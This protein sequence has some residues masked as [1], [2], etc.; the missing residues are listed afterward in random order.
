[1]NIKRIWTQTRFYPLLLAGALAFGAT[2]VLAQDAPSNDQSG[3]YNEQGNAA[4]AAETLASVPESTRSAKLYSVLGATYDQQ[5]DYKKA[6]EMY[7]KAVALD[8]K[9]RNVYQY[10]SAAYTLL[11]KNELAIKG[12]QNQELIRAKIESTRKKIETAQRARM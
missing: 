8:P 1:M 10:R 2:A 4:K 6:E 5:K 7:N 11:G 3:I 9:N 12:Q